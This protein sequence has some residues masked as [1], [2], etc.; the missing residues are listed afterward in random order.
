VGLLVD[1][2]ADVRAKDGMFAAPPIVW[3]VEGRTHAHPGADHV[4]V[5][6]RL[7]AAGSPTEW[8]PPPGAPDPD[9]TLDGLIELVRAASD[10]VPSS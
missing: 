10:P 6:R 7:I 2:G 4:G 8:T 1:G 9:R 3:A 5:A